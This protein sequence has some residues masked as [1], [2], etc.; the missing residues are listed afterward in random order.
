VKG[1]N[2]QLSHQLRNVLT[3]LIILIFVLAIGGYQVFKSYPRIIENLDKQ[4]K[5]LQVQIDALEFVA[6]QLQDAQER[7]KE[8]ELKL[9]LIDKQ[10]VPEVTPAG[11]YRYLNTI[12]SYAGFL[13]FDMVYMGLE[14][15]KGYGQHI[16]TVK[17][18]GDFGTIF[19]FIGYLEKGP[20]IYK[21]RKLQMR[22]VETI[23]IQTQR[24]D[25]IV[26]YEFEILALFAEGQSL[27]P[28]HH[29]LDAVNFVTVKNPFLP[30]VK[31]DLPPNFYD[32]LE[33]ERAE[34]KA[35]MS[36][37]AIVV[38]HNRNTHYI[39]EGDE[40]Y[41]G[42]VK[43]IDEARNRVIFTLD[44]GGIVEDFILELR[45]GSAEDKTKVKGNTAG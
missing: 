9:A 32:L 33:V 15:K 12:L 25:L 16:Y 1:I 39:K 29:T 36:N 11:T 30:Y 21:I 3:L 20:E 24:Q 26:T 7:I 40:V 22:G 2:F 13:K 27:P 42:Y 8:E 38:D 45:F 10:I 19:R 28:V 41:L 23:D 17:G 18:E 35:I 34:V 14:K 6:I 4:L 43:R 31:K 5:N 37:R 44:K